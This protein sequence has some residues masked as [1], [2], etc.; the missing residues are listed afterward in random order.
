MP[1]S[2]TAAVAAMDGLNTDF[3]PNGADDALDRAKNLLRS[4]C[5]LRRDQI[6][7]ESAAGG[8]RGLTLALGLPGPGDSAPPPGRSA[9]PR[10]W[11][12]SLSLRW[13]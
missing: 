1:L 6:D 4:V 3:L 10:R 12:L 13:R 5:S 9:G 7:K 8:F 11:E 2:L